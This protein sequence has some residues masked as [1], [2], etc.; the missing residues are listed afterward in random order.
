[1]FSIDEI[2][3]SLLHEL[4]PFF[5]RLG[6]IYSSIDKKYTKAADQYGF[7]CSGCDDN[8]CMTHFY[9]HTYIEYFYIIMGFK[10]LSRDLRKDILIHAEVVCK[11]SDMCPLNIK[12][13]CILYKQRPMICRMHG[14]PHELNK[15]GM[16][17]HYGEGCKLFMEQHGHK[18]YF[19]FDRTPFYFEMACLENELKDKIALKGKFKKTVAQ[20]LTK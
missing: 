17:A 2:P 11:K 3:E 16:P 1:M 20:M 9:H 4:M 8:C 7:K 13:K 10:L 5:E 12:D 6:S 15:P 14:I 19:S 18:N